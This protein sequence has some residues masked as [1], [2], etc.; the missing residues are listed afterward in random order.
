MQMMEVMTHRRR[1]LISKR[2]FMGLAPDKAQVGDLVV[3]L[4]SGNVPYVLRPKPD[5]TY[6]FMGERYLH[7]TMDGEAM[8]MLDNGALRATLQSPH[9]TM[10]SRKWVTSSTPRIATK[11]PER[12]KILSERQ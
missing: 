12:W 7:G 6:T 10:S 5:G 9:A 2:M 3:I 11:R 1:A 4:F 8:Q